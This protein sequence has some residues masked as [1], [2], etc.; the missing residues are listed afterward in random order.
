MKRY[1]FIFSKANSVNK[2]LPV[3]KSIS[4][5]TAELFGIN[6]IHHYFLINCIEAHN[7]KYAL[8]LLEK[9]NV[10]KNIKPEISIKGS[11]NEYSS[12]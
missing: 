12:V 11:K 2:T 8:P 9:L 6:K 10:P 1:N 4:L 5:E 3:L 7:F